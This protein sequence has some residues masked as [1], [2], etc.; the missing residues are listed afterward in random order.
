MKRH[1]LVVGMVTTLALGLTSNAS[2][3]EWGDKD[4][5]YLGTDPGALTLVGTMPLGEESYAPTSLTQDT[6]YYWQIVE[7]PGDYA[8]PVYSLVTEKP[9]A[10]DPYPTDGVMNAAIDAKLSWT[11]GMNAIMHDVYFGT[12]E[13][14]VAAGDPSAF[15][16]KL[17]DTS[18]DPG[19][20]E[21]FMTYYWKVDEFAAVGTNPG[22]VWTFATFPPIPV[23]I[24]IKPGSP[25]NTFN[26]NGAGV[27]PV[28][29][30]S[31]AD[32]DATQVDP[33]TVLFQGLGVKMVGKKAAKF[34]TEYR[35]TNG[36][37]WVDLVVKIN[38]TDNVFEKGDTEATLTG[39]TYDGTA[40][41][42]SDMIRIVP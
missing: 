8:G 28:A 38:D 33:A 31:S 27:L 5:G 29:I 1:L 9:Y 6:V 19:L 14:A 32:F 30:L 42:G 11:A 2:A 22:P 13:A 41:E 35:D 18:F 39:E 7:Q 26:N 23:L 10:S 15:Q 34:L 36:D 3:L 12:D 16:G 37:G 25:E 21:P 24:D 40:F 20:L 4:I 17:M